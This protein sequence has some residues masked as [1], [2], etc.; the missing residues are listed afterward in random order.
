MPY[1]SHRWL[2]GLLTNFSTIHDRIDRLHELRR[3][4]ADGTSSCSPRRSA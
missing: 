4:K 1:V 3:L 2:G